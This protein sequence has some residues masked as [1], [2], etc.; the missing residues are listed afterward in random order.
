MLHDPPV[1]LLD[2]PTSAMDP[3][4][5]KTVRDAIKNLKASHRTILL[6]TH[7]LAEAEQLAD[8]IALFAWERSFIRAKQ[9]D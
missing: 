4:S 1:L 8:Q 5:A 9:P 2:E 6:C 3:E 7:N